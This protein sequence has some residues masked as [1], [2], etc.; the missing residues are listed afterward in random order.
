MFKRKQ[1]PS[2][3][4]EARAESSLEYFESPSPL[5]SDRCSD[6]ECPCPPP[7]TVIPRGTG[8]LYITQEV[9]DFR[10]DA[11]TDAEASAKANRIVE[12]AQR[13]GASIVFGQG[14]AAPILMCEKGARLRNLDLKVAAADA[15]FWWA[16]GLIPLRVTPQAIETVGVDESKSTRIRKI[17]ADAKAFDK[18]PELGQLVDALIFVEEKTNYSTLVEI[19]LS[20]AAEIRGLYIGEMKSA[21]MKLW[22]Q[23]HHHRE[24]PRY[25]AE[26]LIVIT[27]RDAALV[28]P[29]S[30]IG[31]MLVSELLV[32]F[33]KGCPDRSADL[34]KQFG[35]VP[36]LDDIE[37]Y[38]G[39]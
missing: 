22:W 2:K 28:Q 9:V 20:T 8:Y 1:S 25:R 32:W 13:E 26:K 24:D 23:W 36:S 33:D 7:G 11:R 16:N 17:L 39:T 34:R 30:E 35:N 21:Y 19:S 10:R 38:Q 27:A 18:L 37:R 15:S 4:G 6:N 3:S 29:D 5:G 14:V 12:A 31:W